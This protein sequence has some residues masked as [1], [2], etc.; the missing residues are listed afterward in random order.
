MQR[1]EE[2]I[3]KETLRNHLRKKGGRE[4]SRQIHCVL[5]VGR[6]DQQRK[7]E[8]KQISDNGPW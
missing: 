7:P 2:E 4:H 6:N 1:N 8:L 5:L 3:D